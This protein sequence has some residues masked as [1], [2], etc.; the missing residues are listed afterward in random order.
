MKLNLWPHPAFI[1]RERY[2]LL[3]SKSLSADAGAWRCGIPAGETVYWRYATAMMLQIDNRAVVFIWRN[4]A[5]VLIPQHHN[6]NKR[7]CL[8]LIGQ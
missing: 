6:E 4:V 3:G 8:S 2:N 1:E 7:D 5:H